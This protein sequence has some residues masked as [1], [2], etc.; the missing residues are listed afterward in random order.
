LIRFRASAGKTKKNVVKSK[1][2]TRRIGQIIL[3]IFA[4]HTIMFVIELPQVYLYN[5]QSRSPI[6]WWIPVARLAWGVY[7]W[8]LVAPFILWLGYRLPL[9]RPHLRR[10][11]FLHFI[12]GIG[13]GVVQHYGYHSGMWLFGLATPESARAGFSNLA[14]MLN[15]ISSSLFRYATIIAIQQ[16][17]FYFQESK[18]RAFR[19]QQAELEMLKMQ[20][21]P[22][23]FFNTLNAI[24]ALIYRSPKDA[25]RTITQ[26]SDLFRISL[27]KDKAQ[28]VTL[29]EEMEF[30]QAYL[31]IHQ[32]LMGKRLKVEWNIENETLD[33]LVP[34]L[35]LQPLV[36]NAIQ[37]G[38]APLEKGGKIEISS[39]HLNGC[40]LLQVRDDGRGLS[41]DEI[42]FDDGVGLSNTRARL[43]NLYGAAHRFEIVETGGGTSVRLEIPFREQAKI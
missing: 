42:K 21:H 26:L 1:L 10:N 11:L 13:S 31:Q 18:E 36:E 40:L 17:Y 9:A 19:L 8:S 12:F 4:A 25:D 15:F 39:R 43:V 23:F 41:T 27:K 29:K 28:E 6:G 14:L 16:A 2:G 24:S 20:L 30:L 7:V 33:S 38:I 35:I 22:H 5:A 3:L 34:N 37:H 32:T